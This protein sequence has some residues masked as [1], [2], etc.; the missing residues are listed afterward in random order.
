MGGSSDEIFEVTTNIA[1][2]PAQKFCIAWPV[3]TIVYLQSMKPNGPLLEGQLSLKW[4]I[5]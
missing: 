4:S 2:I 5:S 1:Q 3:F